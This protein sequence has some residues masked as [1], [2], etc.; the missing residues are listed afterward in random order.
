M[1]KP[2]YVRDGQQLIWN[3]QE[4]GTFWSRAWYNLGNGEGLLTRTP[5]FVK[6]LA[7]EIANINYT[8]NTI[9]EDHWEKI[10]NIWIYKHPRKDDSAFT[11]TFVFD[12]AVHPRHVILN[13]GVNSW[14]IWPCTSTSPRHN[15]CNTKES[16][17]VEFCVSCF[18]LKCF[19]FVLPIYNQ[20]ADFCTS[21]QFLVLFLVFTHMNFLY[22][23]AV[24]FNDETSLH[25]SL[26]G[27]IMK[28][29]P[30]KKKEH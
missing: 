8:D 24:C 30:T 14:E 21:R 17:L 25:S 10:H 9:I 18:G 20:K 23:S 15:S 19:N 12:I 27:H 11:G 22:F 16:L 26:I 3:F 13:S 29:K 2:L 7:E 5:N 6:R 1:G 4:I 28:L